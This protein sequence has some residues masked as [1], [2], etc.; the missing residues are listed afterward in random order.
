MSWKRGKWRLTVAHESVG[1]RLVSEK[2]QVE[3]SAIPNFV[4]N[5]IQAPAG[6]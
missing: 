2:L 6:R 4:I 1:E 3:R 5:V